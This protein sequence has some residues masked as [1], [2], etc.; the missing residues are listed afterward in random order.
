VR[1]LAVIDGEHYAPVVRDAIAAVPYDVVAAVLVGGTEKLRGA[2]DYGVPL[3]PGLEEGIAAYAPELVLDLS[4]EPVLGPVDRFR[5]ASRVL[6]HGLPYAGADF[7]FDAPAFAP[8]GLPSLA[9]VGTGKRVGKTA[10]TGHVA[11]LLS[12]ERRVVVVAMGRGGPPE[13]EVIRVRPTVEELVALSRQGHHAA[14]DHLETAALVGVET[15]GCRRCGGGLAGAVAI[16][17]VSEGARL[18]AALD[19][20]LVVFDGS[21]AALPPVAVARRLLVVGANQDRAVTTGYLNAY[22]LRLAD[23]VVVGLAEE[24]SGHRSLADAL[25]RLAKPDV[26]VVSTVLR[27]QPAE[28]VAGRAVAYFCT[29]PPSEHAR[30]AAHLAEAYGAAVVH[31]SGNLADRAAL[32]AELP[33]VDAEVFL[34]ELKAAAIDLV[35]EEA[36]VRGARTILAANAVVPLAGEPDLDAE[37]RRLAEEA[38]AA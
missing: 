7:R 30:L 28:P 15:V 2:A 8:F 14:S 26:A 19:P 37:V 32:R 4:D 29:A 24:G 9:V 27:P 22:R 31:V 23:L 38:L 36:V 12:A 21:G 16:S 33:G 35:A 5:L 11:R 18:A 10:V 25:R 1:A 20:E 3:A 34:V 17:N 13:P 6:A